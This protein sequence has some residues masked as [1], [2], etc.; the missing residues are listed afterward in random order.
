[1]RMTAMTAHPAPFLILGITVCG[2]LSAPPVLAADDLRLSIGRVV[3]SMKANGEWTGFAVRGERVLLE[4][5]GVVIY[6]SSP[7]NTLLDERAASTRGGMRSVSATR[8]PLFEGTRG[9]VRSPSLEPD[10]D[11]DGHIDEDAWDRNDNDGDGEVDEDFAAIGDEMAVAVYGSREITVRQENYAW[12]LPHI[13]GMVASTIVISNAGSDA[14]RHARIGIELEVGSG[15]GVGT[16]PMIE[17]LGRS[18]ATNAAF[19]ERHVVFDNAERGLAALFFAS[20]SAI[21]PGATSAVTWEIRGDRDRIVAVS[22]DFGD[23][24]PGSSATVY[25]ALVALPSDDLKA[26]RAIRNARR[27]IVGDGK[28][29][30]IPPPVSRMAQ[31]DD[32]GGYRDSGGQSVTGD[33]ADPFWTTPGKLAETLIVGSPNPFR[34]AVSIDYE[35]P[36]RVTDEDGVEH[37]LDDSGHPTSVK[38]YNVAGRLVATLVDQPQSPGRYRTDWIARNEDGATVASGVYYV[39]LQIGKRSVT[40]RMVQLK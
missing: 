22:P 13:D 1:M 35:I 5:G 19:V 20:R 31:G 30:F 38:V 10:D 4:R 24:A 34:D 6:A 7:G 27:T 25:V 37:V 33:D 9:G 21:T 32:T 2:V 12:S 23:L 39:K 11:H 15:L 16:G 40:M 3:F 26:A 14:V 8:E 36:S 17:G 18:V 29:R 28:T